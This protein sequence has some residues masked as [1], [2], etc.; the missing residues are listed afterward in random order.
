MTQ[1]L[2]TT[3]NSF[4]E[5]KKAIRNGLPTIHIISCKTLADL[6][7]FFANVGKIGGE[8]TSTPYLTNNGYVVLPVF[9]F[10]HI[11]N[12]PCMASRSKSHFVRDDVIKVDVYVQIKF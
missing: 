3:L 12:N 6:L 4:S 5:S 10:Q 1:A 9:N 2:T 11:E 8:D 7:R